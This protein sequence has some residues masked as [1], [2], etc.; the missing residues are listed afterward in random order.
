[1][2]VGYLAFRWF[3]QSARVNGTL[4]QLGE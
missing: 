2:T 1:L 4:L 3:L